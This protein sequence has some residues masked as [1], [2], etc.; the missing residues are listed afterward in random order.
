MGTVYDKTMKGAGKALI[1]SVVC[2]GLAAMGVAASINNQGDDATTNTDANPYGAIVLRNVFGLSDAVVIP[3]P[4]N[5]P[6][7]PPNV[8]LIG[9]STLMSVP[10]AIV[11]VKPPTMPGHPPPAEETYIMNQGERQGT[12]E[13]VAVNVKAGTAKI[14]L[15]G[16]E[17]T[18]SMRTNAPMRAGTPMAAAAGMIPRPPA[19]TPP[20]AAGYTPPAPP[21]VASAGQGGYYS[22]GS[23][24]GSNPDPASG[25]NG[26][27][28][29]I[30]PRPVRT[31]QPPQLS[32]EEQTL[33]I[34]AQRQ[35]AIQRGDS[36]AIILPPT[37][38]SPP[39][40][41]GADGQQTQNPN[42]SPGPH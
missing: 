5:E 14:K 36:V 2:V 33:M 26:G 3:P 38:M 7:P 31:D 39:G 8:T 23:P 22:G 25:L 32:P 29:G 42:V 19:Y 20:A 9:L 28:N 24:N 37:E 11:V 16:Q 15:E 13:L 18:I 6:A 41:G 27:Q 4:T 34:E 17:S 30:P 40:F 12:L 35:D 21:G 10:Q 1:C